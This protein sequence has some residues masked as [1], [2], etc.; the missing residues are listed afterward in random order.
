MQPLSLRHRVELL[1][2]SQRSRQPTWHGA[3]QQVGRVVWQL[4][5]EGLGVAAQHSIL[6]I[7]LAQHVGLHS[8][9]LAAHLC[10]EAG[11]GQDTRSR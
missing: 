6:G 1:R 3:E 10:R 2:L 11:P 4:A 8:L 7:K 5:P 9:Q